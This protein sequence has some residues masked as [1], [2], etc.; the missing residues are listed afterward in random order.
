M[1]LYLNDY[2]KKLSFYYFY[3]LADGRSVAGIWFDEM[4]SGTWKNQQQRICDH[5]PGNGHTSRNLFLAY[6]FR[7][8]GLLHRRRLPEL[9]RMRTIGQW[10]VPFQF[11]LIFLEL[12]YIF[13][14]W[15]KPHPTVINKWKYFFK[16]IKTEYFFLY[17]I[18]L[19]FAI[20]A[21]FS[22]F[23]NITVGQWAVP[24]QFFNAIGLVV[25][26]IDWIFR[27]WDLYNLKNYF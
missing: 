16:I 19:I 20:F 1:F 7:Q 15:I 22:I 11:S 26:L 10:A 24:F 3:F 14:N 21:I 6:S 4:R 9:P 8:S 13:P 27:S 5:V 2:L 17:S 12:I 18:F 23:S 25:G